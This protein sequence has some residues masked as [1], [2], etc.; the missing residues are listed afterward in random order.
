MFKVVKAWSS[1]FKGMKT[2]EHSRRAKVCGECPN[3][4]YSMFLDFIKDELKEVEG[5]ICDECKCPLIA[6][7][8]STDKCPL[9]KW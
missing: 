4:S 6:K 1:V 9:G 3:K 7:I 2:E 8:R 5:Y